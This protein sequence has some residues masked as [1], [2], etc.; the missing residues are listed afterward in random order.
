MSRFFEE[1][2]SRKRKKEEEEDFEE[3]EQSDVYL[4][5][6]VIPATIS[7]SLETK[8]FTYPTYYYPDS[9]DD[10]PRKCFQHSS[11]I[12]ISQW[13]HKDDE[14]KQEYSEQKRQEYGE[15]KRPIVVSG[16]SDDSGSSSYSLLGQGSNGQVFIGCSRNEREDKKEVRHSCTHAIK[17]LNSL[18]TGEREAYFLF[19]LQHLL[20]NNKPVTPRLQQVWSCGDKFFYVMDRFQD[21]MMRLGNEQ[22]DELSVT[23][24]PILNSYKAIRGKP[25]LYTT[26]QLRTM[27][28]ICYTLSKYGILMGDMKPDQFLYR[29]DQK[30]SFLDIVITDF[31][32]TKNISQLLRQAVEAKKKSARRMILKDLWLGWT[33]NYYECK[34]DLLDMLLSVAVDDP[35]TGQKMLQ[36]FN[37]WQLSSYLFQHTTFVYDDS[38]PPGHGQL[39]LFREYTVHPMIELILAENCTRFNDHHEEA[40]RKI[41]FLKHSMNLPLFT[42]DEQSLGFY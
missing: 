1:K 39:S 5:S 30:N 23:R 22:F 37:M 9:S 38:A 7:G 18:E 42:M 4:L 33:S 17:I 10:D 13:E 31:G 40:D 25:A 3:K 36:D 41:D 26:Y 21:N 16:N 29:E 14:R 15:R 27:F 28:Q 24:F 35:S 6:L 12:P 11:I 19:L 8:T 32:Y 34:S 2:K 20:L